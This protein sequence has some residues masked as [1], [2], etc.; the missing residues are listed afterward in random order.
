[1]KRNNLTLLAAS[2]LIV[3]GTTYV[4][5][6]DVGIVEEPPLA[7]ERGGVRIGTL[8]CDLGGGVG[9]VVGSA[10]EIDCTFSPYGGG[11]AD[12]YTGQVRK[13]GIDLGYTSGG[14]LVWAVFAPTAGDHAGSLGGI[15]KGASAEVSLFFGGGAN[16]LVGGTSG[17]IHLQLLSVEGLRGINVSAT[18]TS[19]TLN[20]G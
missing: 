19:M 4:R 9:Y 20:P 7:G 11:A 2:A 17:S 18:G 5:A 3:A 15:Y 6:A 14:K 8:Y 1:M 13:M 12:S 16:V 10:K